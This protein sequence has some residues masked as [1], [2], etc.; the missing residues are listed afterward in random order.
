MQYL[1]T[2]SPPILHRDLKSGNLLVDA[3]WRI[4]ITDFGLART[5]ATSVQAQTQV[6]AQVLAMALGTAMVLVPA[7]VMASHH[8]CSLD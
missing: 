3:D 6:T 7:Q 5:K 1:H 8:W 4:K 2:R